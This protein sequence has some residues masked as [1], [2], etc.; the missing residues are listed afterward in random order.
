[1]T[2]HKASSQR[3]WELPVGT[4]D[5]LKAASTALSYYQTFRDSSPRGATEASD[6]AWVEDVIEKERGK[7]SAPQIVNIIVVDDEGIVVSNDC[8]WSNATGAPA[9]LNRQTIIADDNP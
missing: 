5:I 8:L 3:P 4:P 9:I 7:S 2:Q 1:M 6:V